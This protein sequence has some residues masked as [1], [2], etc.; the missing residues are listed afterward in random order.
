[1]R[2]RYHGGNPVTRYVRARLH[3]RIFFLLGGSI[4]LTA[5][6][7]GVSQWSFGGQ[8][9]KQEMLAAKTFV[10]HSFEQVWDQHDARDALGQRMADD[11]RLDVNLEDASHAPLA[12]FGE[13]CTHPMITVPVERAGAT[14]GYAAFCADRLHPRPRGST[15]LPVLAAV[16]V[17]WAV[18]GRLARRLTR[19]YG[20]LARV[21]H[22][23]GMGKLSSR[24]SLSPWN[25]DG[26]AR[27]LADAIN[28]MAARIEKQ[29]KDQ[30]ELLAGVSHEIRTPLARI[31]LLVELCRAGASAPGEVERSEDVGVLRARRLHVE[32][33]TLDEIDREVVE[34]D[35]LVSELLASS[36]LDFAALSPH[37]LDSADLASRALERLAVDA[38][39]LRL[40]TA[41]TKLT[42]DATLLARALA[43]LVENA[44]T[45]GGGLDALVVRTAEGAMIFEALDRGP[46]FLPGEE[47]RVFESFY[48]R[49]GAAPRQKGALG[50]GLTLVKRIAEAHGGK[51]FA[52]NREG[53]GAS[54]GMELPV[55]PASL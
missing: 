29:M 13:P 11:L 26:E 52:R 1:V 41:S 5:L 38:G 31:R 12:S 6:I 27:M 3:R 21:A 45:H 4:F 54:V 39:K 53:G 16:F 7:F 34:I 44:T 42:A 8:Q 43:N 17:L 49:P 55:K 30:R 48:Q 20:E 47:A 46:G 51:A 24:F 10:S 40:E 25:A 23:I 18:S 14:L 15:L 37:E 50:L 32:A 9:W 35:A 2:H 33:K 19:P 22:D 28:D 36:R